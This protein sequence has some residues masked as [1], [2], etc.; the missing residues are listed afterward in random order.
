MATN[1]PYTAKLEA[2][3]ASVVRKQIGIRKYLEGGA[4]MAG[5]DFDTGRNAEHAKRELAWLER[6]K[7][8]LYHELGRPMPLK[9]AIKLDSPVRPTPTRRATAVYLD[10]PTVREVPSYVTRDMAAYRSR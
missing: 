9:H 4:Y 3:L 10:K 6:E 7:A 1:N 8:R 2:E 5:N